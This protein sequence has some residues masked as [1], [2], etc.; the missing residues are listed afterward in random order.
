MLEMYGY[1]NVLTVQ[2]DRMSRM[3]KKTGPV[4]YFI[5]WLTEQVQCGRQPLQG[6]RVIARNVHF[7]WGSLKR[8]IVVKLFEQVT[9]YFVCKT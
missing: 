2:L 1:G 7:V 3:F 6:A 9:L 5:G 4:D 8:T